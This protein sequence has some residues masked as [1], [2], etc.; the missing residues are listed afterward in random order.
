MVDIAYKRIAASRPAATTEAELYAVP[1]D[2]EIV[3]NLTIVNQSTSAVTFNV[4]HTDASG[5]AAG[6]DWLAFEESLAAKARMVIPI[7]AKNPETIRI[8]TDTVDVTSFHLSGMV[9]S[10]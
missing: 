4:A 2:T 10:L 6:E 3:G 1:S 8:Q 7:T 9:R 5:A